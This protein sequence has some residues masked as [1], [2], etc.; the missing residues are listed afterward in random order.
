MARLL[1]LSCVPIVMMALGS[2]EVVAFSQSDS[3]DFFETRIRPLLADNCY[4]CHTGSALGGLRVDTRE[5]LLKG[6]KSGP[7]IVP[8]NPD[9]SLL[10]R[11]VRQTD[12]DLKMP[13]NGKLADREIDDLVRWIESGAPWPEVGVEQHRARNAGSAVSHDGRSF[14]AFQPL[15]RPVLPLVQ[16]SRW[17]GNPI[18]HF[19][20]A[21][22]EARGLRPVRR[23]DKR[24]LIRRATFDLTG[25]PPT[26]A[27]VDDFLADDSTE[28][29]GRVVDRLL[30]SPHYGER[31]ARHWL[32]VARY[33]EDDVRGLSQES[34]PNAW[35]YRDWVVQAFN[36]DLPYDLFIKAQLAADLLDQDQRESLFPALGFFGLGPWYYDIAEPLQARADERNDR[37]DALTRGVLGLTVACAR[38]HD[39]KYDPITIEDYYGLAGVFAS[40]QYA[41]YPLADSATVNAYR[42]HQRRIQKQETAIRDFLQAQSR[43]LSEMLAHQTARYLMGAWKVMSLPATS[44]AQAAASDHLDS[45]TLQRWLHYLRGSERAHPYLDEWDELC[46]QGASEPEMREA[47]RKFQETVL[48]VLEEKNRI[49]QENQVLKGQAKLEYRDPE[50]LLPNAFVTYEDYCPGCSVALKSLVPVRFALWVDLFSEHRNDRRTGQKMPGVLQY[51]DESLTRFLAGIWKDHLDS[52]RDELESLKRDAPKPFPYLHGIGDLAAAVDLQVHLRGSPHNLGNAAPRRFLTV[53][54]DQEPRPFQHGSGRLELAEAI[55]SHPLTARV[56]VNRVWHHHFGRGLVSTPSN[57]GQLGDRPSHPD[58]LEYLA[59]FFV[60]HRY[61]IKVLHRAILTSATYQL[62]CDH[63]AENFAAD[64]DNRLWWRSNRRRLDVES[65]RDALL[66]VAGNLNGSLGGPSA[67]LDAEYSRRTLYARISRFRLAPLLSLFDFPD[68]SIS[69]E[70]R[71]VTQVPLQRLFF[72]NSEFVWR[73]AGRL[74]ERVTK[75]ANGGDR[76][77]IVKAYRL[78]YGRDPT[79]EE[80]RLGLKF[81]SESS[82]EGSTADDAAWQR[83]AQVLLSANEFSFVN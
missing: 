18:D 41:E 72:M 8:G 38:C 14:W 47:S 79:P 44:V 74:A 50:R 16:D 32:D 7:A 43:Q 75:P 37:I 60:E 53:L 69:S 80:L 59:G 23:A 1:A 68:P 52:L 10:V 45:E 81:L 29:F 5:S 9:D 6:G 26:P 46:S 71:N 40:T 66:F 51:K 77:S 82:A 24:T 65:L 21:S 2:A 35:R 28:A 36:H 78:L 64:P 73:Q 48:S 63:S 57:F 67:E 58:L 39:H 25:L 56:L 13:L 61:S 20:L 31:W 19:V 11:A 22:L 27:E 33:A 15:K 55:V 83:Y 70:R 49:D 76:S 30:A 3:G 34:Y 4:A 17:P 54:S 62:A 42:Q 12:S